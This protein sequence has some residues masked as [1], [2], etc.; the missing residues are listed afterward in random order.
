MNKSFRTYWSK[1]RQQCVVVSEAQKA[2]RKKRGGVVTQ[3]ALAVLAATLGTAQAAD[4][5]SW[6]VTGK[7]E[8]L[9]E[10]MD[11]SGFAYGRIEGFTGWD[12]QP[13]TNKLTIAEGVTMTGGVFR[14]ENDDFWGE[15]RNEGEPGK[16]GL[17]RY[18]TFVVNGTLKDGETYHDV[19]TNADKDQVGTVNWFN[20]LAVGSTG[21]VN[22]QEIRVSEALVNEGNLTV[23]NLYVKTG[24][25]L[26]NSGTININGKAYLG[27][28][29]EI[30][31][32]NTLT[33]DYGVKYE[34]FNKNITFVN[35]GT[36]TGKGDLFTS[37]NISDSE[38][39]GQW[40]LDYWE[41]KN[42]TIQVN[43]I[44][45]SHLING[46]GVTFR[47]KKAYLGNLYN[48]GNFFI[49]SVL[50]SSED[51]NQ[52][53]TYNYGYL[54]APYAEIEHFR[55]YTDDSLFKL[56]VDHESTI[57][58]VTM[59][60][61]R[62]ES[63]GD[64]TIAENLIINPTATVSVNGNIK[65]LSSTDYTI[66][67]YLYG[68]LTAGKSAT[69]QEE[70][71]CSA[72]GI[73]EVG[74]TLTIA[75]ALVN[76]GKVTAGVFNIN[77]VQNSSGTIIATDDVSS[78]VFG[79]TLNGNSIK[80]AG[81]AQFGAVTNSGTI[82]LEKDTVMAS[83]NQTAGLTTAKDNLT[84]TGDSTIKGTISVTNNLSGGGLIT[85][86]GSITADAANVK[87]L[88]NG[89]TESTASVLTLKNLDIS[90]GVG[91]DRIDWVVSQAVAKAGFVNYNKLLVS[92]NISGTSIYNHQGGVISA[93]DINVY[94]L[95]N[96]LPDNG[97][98]QCKYCHP[99]L[100]TNQFALS[101]KYGG[102]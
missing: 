90:G 20:R 92:E 47:S 88:V 78:S 93:R 22:V 33:P 28:S 55:S 64:V 71:T 27:V 56:T 16:T 89:S 96:C 1:V 8:V 82:T 15:E 54:E 101:H 75:K 74:E 24:S 102:Y 66:P 72:T 5:S 31:N 17:M 97:G 19:A 9:T 32:N 91:N 30:F 41:T 87:R 63:I 50:K 7:D 86:L 84:L 100:G 12:S 53:D 77:E 67:N 46:K 38:D 26:S 10:D 36:I 14:Y 83:L 49:D 39:A 76:S 37:V 99:C 98:V 81:T 59:E 65:A 43:D 58:S 85:N 70:V 79:K 42:G 80:L 51:G 18:H 52:A 34:D 21:T 62:L 29:H 11:V 94:D 69:F 73:V 57:R 2:P 40:S 4:T 23:G 6:T 60:K 61:G 35:S 44:K 68:H 48:L 3:V 25:L 45:I 13:D 95:L